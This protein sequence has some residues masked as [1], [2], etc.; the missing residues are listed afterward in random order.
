[1]YASGTKRTNGRAGSAMSEKRELAGHEY[2]PQGV[3]PKE[4]C[5][6][7]TGIILRL[8]TP[9]T[10]CQLLPS[11]ISLPGHFSAVLLS[12]NVAYF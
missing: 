2:L 11:K 12:R 5:S 3:H 1:M 10:R 8:S 7:Y 4:L 9:S 6:D